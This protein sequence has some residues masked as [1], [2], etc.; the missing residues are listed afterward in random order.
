[1]NHHKEQHPTPSSHPTNIEIISI[2]SE[3]MAGRIADT[4]AA[5]LSD[6]ITRAGLT[7]TRHTAVGD[8]REHVVEAIRAA[9]ERA[10]AVIITGG[11]GPTPDDITRQA[12]AEMC[13]LPLVEIPEALQNLRAFFARLG[14]APS[15]SNLIQASIPETAK[16]IPNPTGTASGFRMRHR[17]CA[18]Y[19]LPGVPRE[20]KRMFADSVLPELRQRGGESV[21]IRCVQAYG[22]GE[23]VIGERLGDLMGENRNP[24]VATQA[25]EGVITIRVT[26]RGADEIEAQARLAPALNRIRERLG[27][28]V[29][30]EGETSLA[31]AVAQLLEETDLT[32]AIAESC[33]GGELAA[34]LTDV[35]GISRFFIEAA[36]TYGNEAKTR[37]LGVPASLIQRHG[38]VS[39]Q[40]ANAMAL[41]MRKRSHA[42][43][44][45]AVT[46]IAGPSGGS[47]SK[48]VGLVYI[49]LADE[50][51][52]TADEARFAGDRAQI[53][54]RAVKRALN[55]LRL[56][57]TGRLHR[58]D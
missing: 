6:Q 7:V 20:M 18:L 15:E 16:L 31:G 36:V 1:M 43:I 2:G 33:T 21:I 17:G 54:N 4:N 40:V 48:P 23:S 10:D 9:A 32:L 28:V 37:R 34:R 58:N 3:L 35:P 51:G 14:R 13:G 45:L 5:H 52:A 41:G 30:A 19:V 11:I 8:R 22:L 46:G 44:A 50:T 42:D 29:F 53:R 24:E 25:R 27:E 55:R 39:E 26:A 49:A 47:K 12:V 38:A 57:L 56:Y